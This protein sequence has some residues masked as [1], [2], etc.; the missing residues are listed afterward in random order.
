MFTSLSLFLFVAMIQGSGATGDCCSKCWNEKQ[1]KEGAASIAPA[2]IK[3][4]M[5]VIAEEPSPMEVEAVVEEQME[6]VP[7]EG[8]KKRKKKKASYKNMM[9]GITQGTPGSKD[10][11]QERE[12]LRQVTGGGVFSKIDKI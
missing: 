8:P 11:E 6:E 3:K 9:A 5:N 12:R 10:I 4:S 2:E 7:A 1:K